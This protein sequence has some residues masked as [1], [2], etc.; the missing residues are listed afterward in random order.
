[1]GWV[2]GEKGFNIR[3]DTLSLE[4][5]GVLFIFRKVHILLLSSIISQVWE[6]EW[7]E[8]QTE[9]KIYNCP[10]LWCECNAFS[11]ALLCTGLSRRDGVVKNNHGKKEEESSRK[12]MLRPAASLKMRV[13]SEF[14][15]SN[16]LA[17]LVGK[18]FLIQSHCISH[19]YFAR[20]Q[21]VRSRVTAVN[22]FLS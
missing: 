8:G 2:G 13:Q 12:K 4:W 5:I 18:L 16:V 6:E 20:H 11:T 7:E 3:P 9:K 15:Y 19:I 17:S 1:M 10:F 21:S 14:L 22:C